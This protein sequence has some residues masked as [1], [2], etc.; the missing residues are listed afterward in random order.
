MYLLLI[1]FLLY[2]NINQFPLPYNQYEYMIAREKIKQHDRG[3]QALNNF[4]SKEKIVNLYFELLRTKDFLNTKNYFYPSRPI[5]TFIENI[6][7]NQFYQ[8]LTLLPKGG[9]LHLHE[10]QVLDRKILLESIKNS[11]EYDIL[12]I[13]DKNNCKKKYY[14][15]YFK[16]NIPLGWT[17]VKGSNWTIS[18]IIKKT[19]LTGILNNLDKPIYSTDTGARWNLTHQTG[20]FDFYADLINY[21]VTKYNYLKLILDHS[22]NDNVQLLEFRRSSLGKKLFYFHEN[23]SRI[24]INEIDELNFLLKFKENYMLNNPKLIDFIFL[25]HSR[26][27]SSKERVKFEINNL[28][29]LHK[30]YPDLIR[31]YDM[32]GEEDQGHTLLFHNE[33]LIHLFNYSKQT[34]NS[35]NLV[36][37]AGET[38]WP[39]EYLPSN[40]GDG[41]STFENIYDAL[42]LRTQRIG[43]GLSLA[44]RPDMYEYIRK[45][46]IAIEICPA[47][48]QILGQFF[49]IYFQFIYFDVL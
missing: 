20:F 30:L 17:K 3:V 36:F 6:T 10:L 46:Q 47:S 48:N 27:K 12:Y 26:K 33:N 28:I 31:G 4:N 9:N 40:Y 32:V 25:I 18:E 19:T 5:E 39:E 22:L 21:N 34:N 1:F 35:F 41:V 7:N 23:G 16:R 44:K 29:K 14:L 43:H 15:N 24:F 11:S 8:F 45:N 2:G 37:H 42:V 13:C 49:Y 38:N